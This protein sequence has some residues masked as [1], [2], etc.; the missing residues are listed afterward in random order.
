MI[1]T[2]VISVL[3]VLVVALGL[4]PLIF[5]AKMKSRKIYWQDI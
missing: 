4:L 1:E 3:S 2:V 5:Y